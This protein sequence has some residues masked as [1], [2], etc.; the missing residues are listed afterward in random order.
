MTTFAKKTVFEFLCWVHVSICFGIAIVLL[1]F[2]V[3][4]GLAK[5]DIHVHNWYPVLAVTSCT[6]DPTW[7]LTVVSGAST[8]ALALYDGTCYDEH[9][10]V[11]CNLGFKAKFGDCARVKPH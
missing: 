4:R 3:L 9:D 8:M 5:R 2:G 1:Q 11:V 10:Q 7:D 6:T